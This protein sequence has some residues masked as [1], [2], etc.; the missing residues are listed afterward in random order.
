MEKEIEVKKRRL[1]NEWVEED[2]IMGK[3]KEN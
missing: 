3:G 1:D 2:K